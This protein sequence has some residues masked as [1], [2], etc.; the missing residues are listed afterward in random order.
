VTK[1][2]QKIKEKYG[3]KL[4]P[5]QNVIVIG[6]GEIGKPL[7]DIV[8]KNH[9]AIGVDIEP[10]EFNDEVDILHICYP[11]QINDFVTTSINYVEKYNPGLVIINSTVIPGTTRSIGRKINKPIAYSPVRGKHIKMKKDLL[12]YTKY[13]AGFNDLA[14]SMAV[15]HFKSNGMKTKIFTSLECLE[16]AKLISTTYF[17]LLIAWAQEMER[18]CIKFDIDYFE[19]M[20]FT[21]EIDYFPPVIFKP[22]YIGGH[23]IVPNIDLLKQIFKSDF[24]DAVLRSNEKKAEEIKKDGKNFN[25]RL[26]PVKI[27]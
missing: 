18:F 5:R 1:N 3:K 26:N 2:T 24:L 15:N 11:Y 7:F 16:L 14:T 6:L 17:G 20:N 25:E 19:L 12:F 4:R 21:K 9:Q 23:C 27:E 22:G 8:R 10:Q 13:V